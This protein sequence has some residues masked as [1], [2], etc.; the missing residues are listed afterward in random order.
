MLCVR[1]EVSGRVLH[2]YPSVSHKLAGCIAAKYHLWYCEQGARGLDF[3]ETRGWKADGERD[4]ARARARIVRTARRTMQT[5]AGPK[6]CG[7]TRLTRWIQLHYELDYHL[8]GNK[9]EMLKYTDD[10]P[11]LPANQSRASRRNARENV[12]PPLECSII[13]MQIACT[14]IHT[15]VHSVSSGKYFVRRDC[16]GERSFLLLDCF[17]PFAFRR[18]VLWWLSKE[19]WYFS[20][21]WIFFSLI[22]ALGKEM[23]LT[24]YNLEIRNYRTERGGERIIRFRIINPF[25]SD[26]GYSQHPTLTSY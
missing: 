1:L 4:R 25:V 26:V 9:R 6:R 22:D 14:G 7:E 12:Q 8:N 10:S 3:G 17:V 24:G 11:P 2:R 15:C 23:E 5:M 18:F 13:G 16:I 21:G 20:L 19:H